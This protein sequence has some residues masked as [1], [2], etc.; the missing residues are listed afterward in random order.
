MFHFQKN[1]FLFAV[2]VVELSDSEEEEVV[3]LHPWWC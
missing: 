2:D 3:I 1:V